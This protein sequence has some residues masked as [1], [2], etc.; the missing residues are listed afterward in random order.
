MGADDVGANP[1]SDLRAGE[2]VSVIWHEVGW[3]DVETRRRAVTDADPRDWTDAA[4]YAE[5]AR[6]PLEVRLKAAATVP[7]LNPENAKRL[8]RWRIVKRAR[9]GHWYSVVTTP[10]RGEL[11]TVPAFGL[12]VKVKARKKTETRYRFWFMS[13]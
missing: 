3:A 1:E 4:A 6:G 12:I 13:G 5:F 8:R 10:K 9:S 7:M 2:E 11:M